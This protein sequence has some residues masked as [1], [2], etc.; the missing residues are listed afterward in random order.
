MKQSIGKFPA[1]WEI[2]KS[3]QHTLEYFGS[4]RKFSFPIPTLFLLHTG[5][6][7][8]IITTLPSDSVIYS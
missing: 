4:M 6:N 2:G 8:C 5:K 1:R 7:Y 3:G